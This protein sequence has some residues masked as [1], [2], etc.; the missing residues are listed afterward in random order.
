MKNT[1]ESPFNSRYAS[2]E[3]QELFSPDMKFKTWRRLWIALAEAEKELGLNITDEQINELKKYKDDINY[4]VAEIKEKEFRHDVMAHIHAYGEQCPNARAIIHLG[5]TSCY[6]GDNT[7]IIIM[8]EALKLIKKKLLAVIAR[9]S[10]FALK[11]KDLPT[12]GFTHYQPAQ[13]V[14]VGKGQL[15]GFR[16]F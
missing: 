6:V 10:D 16:S 12:L 2:K 7:D 4:D 9:L 8:T 15:C 11:Y 5:A 1:Y 3:M 13:L 14:T